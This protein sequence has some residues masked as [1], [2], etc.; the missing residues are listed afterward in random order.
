METTERVMFCDTD[1]AAVVNNIVYLR[2]IETNRSL[3]A[4]KLGWKLG[5]VS[6]SGAYLRSGERMAMAF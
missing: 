3:L 1:A 4:E 5:E 6:V 2:F